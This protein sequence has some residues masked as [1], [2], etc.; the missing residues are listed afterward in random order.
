MAK[1][2]PKTPVSPKVKLPAGVLAAVGVVLLVIGYA[3]GD[4]SVTTAGWS[5]VSA[6]GIT[7]GLGFQVP[8][9]RRK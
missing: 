4:N 8:D 7:A 2:H 1:N 3:I 9:P 6:S 5:A